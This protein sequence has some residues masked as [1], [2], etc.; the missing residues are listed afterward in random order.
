MPGFDIDPER[1][2]AGADA[3]AAVAGQFERHLSDMETRLTGHE[4]A[5]GTDE[6]GSIIGN[7]YAAVT[8]AEA[9]VQPAQAGRRT[10]YRPASRVQ[11]P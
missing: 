3:L 6:I 4:S 9:R 5:F 7:T 2:R 1:L 10:G 11:T 8:D